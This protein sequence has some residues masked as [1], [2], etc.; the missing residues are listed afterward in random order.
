MLFWISARLAGISDLYHLAIPLHCQMRN[1]PIVQRIGL[2]PTKPAIEVRILLRA[3]I[4]NWR[5]GQR[6]CLT[7]GCSLQK[8]SG[9]FA[10]RK[11]PTVD[12]KVS[13]FGSFATCET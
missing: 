3:H 13:K 12:L 2:R 10:Y 8:S 6:R 5:N 4:G 11:R 9:L 1:A 7:P